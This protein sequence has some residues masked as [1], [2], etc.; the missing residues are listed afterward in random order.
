MCVKGYR[1]TLCLIRLKKT[2]KYYPEQGS[3]I[4]RFVI[5]YYLNDEYREYTVYGQRYEIDIIDEILWELWRENNV[6]KR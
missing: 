6:K 5:E 1:R 3:K 4:F 2:T